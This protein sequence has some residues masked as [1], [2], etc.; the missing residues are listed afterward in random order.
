MTTEV[1]TGNPDALAVRIAAIIA[2]AGAINFVIK[3]H[4]K[5]KYIILWT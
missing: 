1:F 4:E 2:A 3:T 5:G